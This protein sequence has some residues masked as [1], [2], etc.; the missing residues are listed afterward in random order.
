MLISDKGVSSSYL[1]GH[2]RRIAS[3]HYTAE[4]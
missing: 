2:L 3:P 4:A 1:K